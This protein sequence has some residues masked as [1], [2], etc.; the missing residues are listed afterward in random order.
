MA[1]AATEVFFGIKVKQSFKK[2]KQFIPISK[3]RTGSP[4]FI[5]TTLLEKICYNIMSMYIT[6]RQR[7]FTALISPKAQFVLNAKTKNS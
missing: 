2:R 1:L 3:S 4:K 7:S 6:L 5:K